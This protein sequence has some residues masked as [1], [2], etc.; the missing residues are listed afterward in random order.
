MLSASSCEEDPEVIEP[1]LT[2]N[3]SIRL[4]PTFDGEAVELYSPYINVQGHSMS[5]EQLRMFLSDIRLL[6]SDGTEQ[7]ISEIEFFDLGD[8]PSTRSYEVPAANYTGIRYHIGVPPA[9]N[10]TTDPDFLTS[11]FGPESPLNIQNGMYWSWQNGFRFL[12]YEGRSDATPDDSGDLPSVF[13]IHMG[14]DTLYTQIDVDLPF[15]VSADAQTEFE[16]DWN[17]S[18]SMYSAT[19]TLQFQLPD[20][21]QFHGENLNLGF[22]F[23]DFLI[24]AMEHSVD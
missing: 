22:R 6:K 14:K 12:I 23:Q 19:D 11:Q 13:S 20:E 2:D 24:A 4:A 3:F 16:I 10:G 5:F 8:G 15:T 21:S 17:L 9:L 7:I 1:A 18:K